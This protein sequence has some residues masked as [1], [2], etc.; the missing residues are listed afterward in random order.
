MR[1]VTSCRSICGP[2][3]AAGGAQGG[4]AQARGGAPAPR[5]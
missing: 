3:R 4:Q 2:R 5:A 1:G